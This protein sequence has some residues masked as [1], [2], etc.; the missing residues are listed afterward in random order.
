MTQTPTET[1]VAAVPELSGYSAMDLDALWHG[2]T[3]LT[4]E[5]DRRRVYN[6][7]RDHGF[8]EDHEDCV[9]LTDRGAMAMTALQRWV[10]EQ[11]D[12]ALA[13]LLTLQARATTPDTARTLADLQQAIYDLTDPCG[14]EGTVETIIET[15]KRAMDVVLAGAV[16]RDALKLRVAELVEMQNVLRGRLIEAEHKRAAERAHPTIT[17]E[18]LVAYAIAQETPDEQA[19]AIWWLR[20]AAD[21]A[22]DTLGLT[23]AEPCAGDGCDGVALDSTES[24]LCA[25]C[26]A[27]AGGTQ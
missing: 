7:I 26:A 20:D 4:L 3:V 1:L 25:E 11:R 15:L 13:E 18:T 27:E 2:L 12:H 23:Y 10:Q 17:R 21:E 19:R 22:A 6:D 16:E 24:A 5:H 9:L 8:V 14:D